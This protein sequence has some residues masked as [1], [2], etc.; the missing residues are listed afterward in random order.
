M[1]KNKLVVFDI[2]GT[3]TDTVG[4]HHE[5]FI[6]ALQHM[7]VRHI[8]TNFNAYKHH[9]DSY[10]AKVNYDKQ[11]P[12]I[13]D[14]KRISELEHLL[15]QNIA[16]TKQEQ[17]IQAIKGAVDALTYL[18]KYTEYGVSFATGSLWKPASYKLTSIGITVN[19]NLI[20]AS[21]RIMDRD[22]IVRTSINQAKL[23]Y[24]RN[25]FEKVVSVG[26]GLWDWVTAQNLGL[27]FIGVGA[28]NKK[29]LVDHGSRRHMEDLTGFHL[30][31]LFN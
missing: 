2:D 31:T 26:D 17:G 28:K 16:N 20:T 27:E 15:L 14:E 22:M 13:F 30:N 6:A 18:E 24:N 5:S 21:N 29:T 19:P 1:R 12:D 25:T 8:D 4:L 9:T 10:I 11:M 23:Y 3:I 7:G